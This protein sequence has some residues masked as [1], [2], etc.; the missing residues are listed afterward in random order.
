M[1]AVYSVHYGRHDLQLSIIILCSYIN[2]FT[3]D[4]RIN[5]TRAFMN[6]ATT[7]PMTNQKEVEFWDR[8]AK[9]TLK[10][11]SANLGKVEELKEKLTNLRNL[12]VL[13][14]LLINI[15]WIVFLYTLKFPE[16]IKYNLPDKAFSLLF[17][18]IFSVIMIIQF[19]AMIFHRF[20]T[21]L[22]LLAG[23]R[24]K[25]NTTHQWSGNT[26]FADVSIAPI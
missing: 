18:I 10:P 1:V 21:L 8:L 6:V 23:I 3:V 7:L 17:L 19:V 16:L 26:D 14:L 9:T 22:H 13:V 12:S 5:Q 15:M 24:S 11:E 25:D 4:I 20:E 2:F